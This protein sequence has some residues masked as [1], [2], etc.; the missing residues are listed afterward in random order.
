MPLQIRLPYELLVAVLQGTREGIFSTG[1]MS[2]H[3]SFEVVA[4]PEKLLAAF[5]AALEIGVL[6]RRELPRLS[7]ALYRGRRFLLGP[8]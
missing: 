8:R 3:V 4:S 2:L 5:D 1:I 6:L 7:G